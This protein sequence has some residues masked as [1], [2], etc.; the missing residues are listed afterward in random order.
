MTL[1]EIDLKKLEHNYRSLQKQL[2]PGTKIMGVVKANAYGSWSVSIAH[3]LVDLGIQT[4]AVAYAEE[5]IQLRQNGIQVPLLVFYPQIENFK[6]LIQYDLE[7]ALYS[8]K[9]WEKFVEALKDEKK[10]DYPIHI[11]YNTGLN[12]IGFPPEHID[13]VLDQISNAPVTVKSIYSHLGQTEAPKPDPDTERQIL[14]FKAIMERHNGASKTKPDYHL[15]NTSGI[16]NYPELHLDWVRTGIG[17]YGFANH[18]EWNQSLQPIAT[19]KTIITQIHEI[20]SGETIGYNSGWRAPKDTR[21]AVLPIG[22]AD[23]FS[24]QMGHQKGWVMINGQKAPVIGNVCMDMTMVLIE[25]IPCQEGTEVE[26]LGEHTRA[27][28][29]AENAGTLSYELLTTLGPRIKRVVKS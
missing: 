7:P 8:K 29:L 4:L 21:I 15:L 20:R 13:W 26:I 22:H 3:K 23:G 14:R 2:K 19:L 28:L 18:S 16:F 25:D 1:L 11:K 27:D 9:S 12:R 17:L 6:S 10:S 24:R 5:G